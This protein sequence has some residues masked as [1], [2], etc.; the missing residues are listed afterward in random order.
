MTEESQVASPLLASLDQ[1][2]RKALLG[3]LAVCLPEKDLQGGEWEK[4][5][6][7]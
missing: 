2:E 1:D 4:M 6:L 5:M 7:S 3:L